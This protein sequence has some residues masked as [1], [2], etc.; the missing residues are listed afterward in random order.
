MGDLATAWYLFLIMAGISL[1]LCI[2][3]LL[4]MRCFLKPILYI[5]FILIF[6]LLLGGGFYVYY[7]A[8]HYDVNDHT[9]QVMQGMGILLWILTGIYTIILLCCCSRIRLGI[10]I[11][12]AASD[13][14]RSTPQIIT[15][16]F[17]FF[18]IVGAWVVFWVISAVYVF[19]V[20][21]AV[22]SSNLPLASIQWDNTTRYVWI[23][24]LFGLFWISAFIIGCA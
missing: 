10:A 14:V 4:L 8:D 2:C 21:T 13:F 23:Y 12:D 6:A 18:F 22:K 9:R 16:P 20:G 3:Y 15:V 24:H 19:S 17:M 5:S 1:V 11:M 7:L